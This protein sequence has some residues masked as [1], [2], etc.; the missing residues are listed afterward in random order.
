M[1]NCEGSMALSLGS[2]AS[3]AFILYN[4][5][6]FTTLR[7]LHEVLEA[8]RFARSDDRAYSDAAI[9]VD[10]SR[11]ILWHTQR[12]VERRY[13]STGDSQPRRKTAVEVAVRIS[14][15]LYLFDLALHTSRPG[16]GSSKVTT[17]HFAG[18]VA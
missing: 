7:H 6:C 11:P 4:R 16:V 8:A 10:E 14:K 2:E 5:S 12:V 13:T 17:G 9:V 3:S 1:L 15:S 18:L